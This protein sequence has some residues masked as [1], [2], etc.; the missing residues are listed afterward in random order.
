MN[1]DDNAVAQPDLV[2]G[3]LDH[4]GAPP[5][6]PRS[7]PNFADPMRTQRD[8]PNRTAEEVP[9]F[10]GDLERFQRFVA[11]IDDQIAAPHFAKLGEEY[12]RLSQD[13]TAHSSQE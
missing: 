8:G 13:V 12:R 2:A 10:I 11:L 1:A 5:C 7:V 9:G 3:G 6:E 4:F